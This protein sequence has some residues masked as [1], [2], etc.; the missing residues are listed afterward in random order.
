MASVAGAVILGDGMILAEDV[1]G[2]V[3]IFVTTTVACC[4]IL[5]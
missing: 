1:M 4:T 5:L 3:G 2:V